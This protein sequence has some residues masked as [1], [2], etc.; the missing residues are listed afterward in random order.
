MTSPSKLPFRIEYQNS[1]PVLVRDG[2][3]GYEPVSTE[4]ALLWE[5]LQVL[6]SKGKQ[7]REQSTRKKKSKA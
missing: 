7:Q 2:V 3:S 5:I 4:V 1:H 6:K